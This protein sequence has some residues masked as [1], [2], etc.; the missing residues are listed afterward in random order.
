MEKIMI[1]LLALSFTFL[2]INTSMAQQCPQM[3]GDYLCSVNG[4]SY[5]ARVTQETVNG[6]T[7][8]NVISNGNDLEVITDGARRAV[9]FPNTD[10]RNASYVAS[11]SGQRV[12]VNAS[13]TLYNGSMRL[14]DAT[15]RLNMGLSRSGSFETMTELTF[16]GMNFPVPT[17][18][19]QAI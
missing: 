16:N 14:G 11:C 10:L 17:T 5:T 1:R 12:V 6:V 19:C 4:S 13:G 2:F 3:E 15:M 18:T 9:S 8:F 7:T